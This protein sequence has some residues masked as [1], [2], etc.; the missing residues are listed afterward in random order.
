M[1]WQSQKNFDVKIKKKKIDWKIDS[2]NN[3]TTETSN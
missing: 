1:N 2:L 3:I